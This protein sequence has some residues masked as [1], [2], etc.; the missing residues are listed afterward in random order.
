MYKKLKQLLS[1]TLAAVALYH[2][3]GNLVPVL[4]VL[5]IFF[6]L[7]GLICLVRFHLRMKEIA[8]PVTVK[9]KV[10]DVVDCQGR[11]FSGYTLSEG[12]Q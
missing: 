5:L 8:E 7:K 3:T 2:V 1:P 10:I 9:F 6:G 12:D 4:M 11:Y